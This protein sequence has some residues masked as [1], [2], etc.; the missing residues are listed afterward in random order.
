M[1]EHAP[2]SIFALQTDE[3][4][5]RHA[6]IDQALEEFA[7]DELREA[8]LRL[9]EGEPEAGE[10][11]GKHASSAGEGAPG[12]AQEGARKGKHAQV[13]GKHAAES[14]GGEP[15]AS[16]APD[17]RADEESDAETNADVKTSKAAHAKAATGEADGEGA[18]DAKRPKS[19]RTYGVLGAVA[20]LLL[21]LG[22]AAGANWNPAGIE[23]PS[24]SGSSVAES[25]TSAAPDQARRDANVA[26]RHEALGFDADEMDKVAPGEMEPITVDAVKVKPTSELKRLADVDVSAGTSVQLDVPIVNQLDTSDGGEYLLAGCE[27]ASLTMLLQDCGVKVTKEELMEAT[28]TVPLV[29]DDGLYGNP[30]KAFVGDMHG[31]YDNPGYSVYH[32]PIVA[33][34]QSY[35]LN[36]PYQVVDLTGQPFTVMLKELASGNPCWVITTDNMQPEMME[37]VWQTDEGEMVINWALHSVVVTGYDDEHIYINDPYGYTQ[38]VPYDRDTF[39]Q[40]WKLMGSQCVTIVPTK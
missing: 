24:A 6:R 9:E 39:E 36:Q 15:E 27:I 35:L 40:T 23:A 16:E 8:Y 7:P 37:E 17:A 22:F 10:R 21:V 2:I 26:A 32:A 14:P 4:K 19:F 31:D 20:A 5:A 33:L 13:S 25:S 1:T 11:V 34:A 28:P 3:Q 12:T 38:N 30:N 18:A 29:G